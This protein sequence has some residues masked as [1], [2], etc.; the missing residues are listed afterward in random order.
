MISVT[1][2]MKKVL[3][4]E[5]SATDFYGARVPLAKYLLNIGWQVYAMIPE[6]K[7]YSELIQR[8]GICVIE[9][10]FNRKN[11]G[12]FQLYN[13]LK[14]YKLILKENDF[15][16][17]HSFRFQPNLLNVISGI[18]ESH[19]KIIHI[20][21]LGIAFSNKSLKYQILKF[22][23]QIIFLIKFYFANS[24]IVQNPDDI[25]DIWASKFF[26]S[27]IQQINGSGIDT[28]KFS[29]EKYENKQIRA[30]LNISE[31]KKVFICITRLIWEKGIRELVEAFKI[32]HRQ[33]NNVLLY[34][35]GW[36]D[37]DNPRHVSHDFISSIEPDSGIIFLG[38]R[39][40]I[41]QLLAASDVFIFPS[42]YR[43]GIPRSLLEALAMGLPIITTDMPGCRLAVNSNLNGLLISAR[44]VSDIECSALEI[45]KKNFKDMRLESRRLADVFFKD[46]IIFEQISSLYKL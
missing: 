10:S 41:P 29:P 22:I 39:T 32:L 23:S 31:E 9:Y 30:S 35:V 18:G 2:K 8:E 21:G 20:T 46:T 15:Q 27:K 38:K 11:K 12:F 1:S 19:Q 26:I 43:E 28:I 44:S 17:V 25:N 24:I 36:S 33:N 40:D 4:I 5:N 3:L 34:V 45:L 13:L 6:D 7:I 14:K 42:Y 37:H 16:I